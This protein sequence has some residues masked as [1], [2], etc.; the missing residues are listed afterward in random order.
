[1]HVVKGQWYSFK[2]SCVGMSNFSIADRLQYKRG[3]N[4][5]AMLTILSLD[6]IPYRGSRC[7]GRKSEVSSGRHVSSFAAVNTASTSL[8]RLCS[9]QETCW[10]G[11]SCWL[12]IRRPKQAWTSTMK[13]GKSQGGRWRMSWLFS[14]IT[15][16]RP[17]S[18]RVDP[19]LPTTASSCRSDLL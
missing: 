5:H 11:T 6:P 17:L 13:E 4:K 9:A 15:P 7:P 18:D 14:R 19:T 2:V 12:H 16:S 1:M 8:V 3:L 10:K